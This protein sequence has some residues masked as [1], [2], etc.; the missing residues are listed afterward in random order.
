MSL[1][2]AAVVGLLAGAASAFALAFRLYRRMGDGPGGPTL[3]A[4][5]AESLLI[6]LIALGAVCLA[7]C[8]LVVCALRERAGGEEGRPLAGET[9]RDRLRPA[10]KTGESGRE[11]RPEEHEGGLFAIGRDRGDDPDLVLRLD[12]DESPVRPGGAQ[13]KGEES[14]TD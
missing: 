4:D 5:E 14:Q 12:T 10:G 13:E 1:R 8:G 9:G 6:G 11:L 7:L 3:S 2:G